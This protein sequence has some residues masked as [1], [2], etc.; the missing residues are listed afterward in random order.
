MS[1]SAETLRTAVQHPAAGQLPLHERGSG[2]WPRTAGAE[3]MLPSLPD[4]RPWPRITVVT[5]SFNQAGYLED[6][7]R[8]VLLQAYPNLEYFVV[9][10]G[11]RDGSR[12]I[13]EKY[14]PWIDDWVS[15]PD[16]GQSHA[17]NKGLARATGEVLAWLNSDDCYYPGALHTAAT[18]MASSDCDI[19]I[20]AMDKVVVSADDVQ[21]VKRSSP[22][23]GLPLHPIRILRHGPRADFH[24]IQPPMFW[25]SDLWR[26][27]GGL[28]ERYHFSMDTEWCNRALALGARVDRTDEVLARFSLHP[29]AK[30]QAQYDR[31]LRER[32]LMYVR[33]SRLPEF[34]RLRC[35][36]ASVQPARRALGVRARHSRGLHAAMLRAGGRALGAVD[37]GVHLV[38]RGL[39]R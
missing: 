15:E 2:V 25:R 27:T 10:G 5:P 7:I 11:S 9:D 31:Q 26:R 29:G 23:Q 13:I 30:T 39:D 20:G 28:D 16:R 35:L 21:V 24:L 33:L 32:A 17:I 36:A 19:L 38:W 6:T 18:L 3:A 12:E 1:A 34:R 22:Y 8:S 4:G 37:A 14:S